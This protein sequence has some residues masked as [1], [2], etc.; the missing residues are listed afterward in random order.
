MFFNFIIVKIKPDYCDY[1][2]KF[3]YRVPFNYAKKNNR[4]LLGI[5][6]NID[7]FIYFAPLTSPK[8]KHLMMHNTTDFL[9]LDNGKLG[10]LNLNNMIPVGRDNYE[11]INLKDKNAFDQS[12][13][14]L[15]KNQLKWLNLNKVQVMYHVDNLYTLYCTKLLPENICDRCCDYKLL[16]KKCLE[17]N[18]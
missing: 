18:K 9:K 13:L 15:L 17:Y 6:F 14:N 4:G 16:E 2:R 8:K 1:L 12:Y 5:L 7:E 11:V 10:A 3:D